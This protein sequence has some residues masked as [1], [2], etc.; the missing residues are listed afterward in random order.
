MKLRAALAGQEFFSGLTPDQLEAVAGCARLREFEADALMLSADEPADMFFLL[1]SGSACVS[2]R[3]PGR[4]PM[5]METLGA[6]EMLG[7]SWLAPPYRWQFDARAMER[8][9]T[10]AFDAPCLR[11]RMSSD[12]AGVPLRILELG[13]SAR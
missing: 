2:V 9:W 13:G 8:T 4:G 10:I 3:L 11:R 7:W 5:T 12:P 6:G 1:L